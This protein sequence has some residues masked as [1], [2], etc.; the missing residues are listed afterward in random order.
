NLLT[1]PA[2]P[3]KVEAKIARLVVRPALQR[4]WAQYLAQRG[5]H[6]VCARMGLAGSDAPFAVHCRQHV[7]TAEQFASPDA[8]AVHDQALHRALHVNDLKLDSVA[9]DLSCIGVL[10]AGFCIERRLLQDDLDQI[11]LFGCLC[12][13]AVDDNATDLRLGA[14]LGVAREGGRS[15]GAEVAVDLDRLSACLLGLGV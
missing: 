7:C 1:Q 10:A 2:L 15:L 12:E 5:M 6:D 3:R 11:A 4:G 8:Y 9:D 13:Q 14:E